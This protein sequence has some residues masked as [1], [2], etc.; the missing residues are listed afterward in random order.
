MAKKRTQDD[1][2]HGKSTADYY[3]L[4]TKA[5]EDLAS[6]DRANSPEVS[7]RELRQYGA[8]RHLKL[9]QWLKAVLIKAWMNGAVCYFF[10]W[11]LVGYFKD[12]LD[13]WLVTAIALGFVTDLVTNNILR[14]SE[15]D[16]GAASRWMMFG[17]KRKFVTLPLNVLYAI[18]LMA[19]TVMTYAAMNRIAH[20]GVEPI[21]FGIVTLL[22][23]L[24]LIQFKHLFITILADARAKTEAGG[25]GKH[26]SDV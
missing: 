9:S 15:K 24:L 22:W 13:L 7:S 11:G 20:L 6:A 23:D 17:K 2:E 14:L 5:I 26:E 4:N 18:L 1:S 3:K 10:L 19:L 8:K 21:L 16:E 12:S 25:R